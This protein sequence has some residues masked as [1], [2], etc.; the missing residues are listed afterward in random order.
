MP[1][2]GHR[3]VTEPSAVSTTSIVVLVGGTVVA[4][5]AAAIPSW[6]LVRV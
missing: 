6:G 2:T 1:D 5:L 3:A 4:S